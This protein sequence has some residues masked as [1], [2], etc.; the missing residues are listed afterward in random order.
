MGRLQFTRRITVREFET[1]P[2]D[3]RSELVRGEVRLN[4]PPG[5]RHGLVALAVGR[6][7]SEHVM[8]RRLGLVF[9]DGTG[10]ELPNLA[11]TVRGPDVSFVRREQLPPEGIGDGWLQVAPDLAVEVLSPSQSVAD[12]DEKISDYLTAGT[13]LIWIVDPAERRVGVIE[14]GSQLRWLGESDTLDGGAVLPELTAP[15]AD[16]FDG[17]AP[18]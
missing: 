12:L 10:F 2:S 1:H 7:L 11:A 17:L 14:T 8:S 6:M 18:R 3:K 13:R 15:V 16:F 5:T 4:P 9:G